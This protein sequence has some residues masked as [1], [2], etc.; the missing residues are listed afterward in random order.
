MNYK[1]NDSELNNGKLNNK[2][3]SDNNV[4]LIG[5]DDDDKDK[6]ITEDVKLIGYDNEDDECTQQ[7][8]LKKIKKQE[9]RRR[10][11]AILRRS[12]FIFSNFLFIL[13]LIQVSKGIFFIFFVIFLLSTYL[14]LKITF[15]FG[16]PF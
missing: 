4:K 8:N 9:E 3:K 12:F 16:L 5:Y 14:I 15:P 1:L 2:V 7:C 10:M 13:F 6:L 11:Y